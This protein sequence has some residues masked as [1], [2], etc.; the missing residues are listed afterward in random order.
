MVKWPQM[1]RPRLSVQRR[2]LFGL[3][4]SN[5]FTL[6]AERPPMQAVY[7]GERQALCTCHHRDE[8]QA[9]A[10]REARERARRRGMNDDLQQLEN[11]YF[12]R[13]MARAGGG[14]GAYTT[15]TTIKWVK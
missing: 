11:Q 15:G 13:R 3:G 4:D 10:C 12:M 2:W 1:P 6:D 14:G 8:E 5:L 7:P 9:L